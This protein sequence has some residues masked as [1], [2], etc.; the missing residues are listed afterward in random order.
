M[1]AIKA[2]HGQQGLAAY[3]PSAGQH[4][5]VFNHAAPVE[6][7][8]FL[9]GPHGVAQFAL[10]VAAP[11]ATMH[12]C[13]FWMGLKVLERQCETTGERAIVGI[14]K[15]NQGG[16]AGGDALVAGC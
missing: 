1:L 14:H 2:A 7:S 8:T 4:G 13:E 3:G 15:C 10:G 5:F 11:P 6:T 12:V 9:P 16:I